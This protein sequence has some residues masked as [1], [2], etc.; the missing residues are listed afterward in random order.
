MR[1]W[2]DRF[3]DLSSESSEATLRF[4]PGARGLIL[5]VRAWLIFFNLPSFTNLRMNIH[6]DVDGD[7][8]DLLFSSHT[9]I[10]LSDVTSL[11]FAMKEI[12]F[13]FNPPWGVRLDTGF[14]YHLVLS[15]DDYDGTSESHI[16][17]VKAWPIPANITSAPT[18]EGLA[19]APYAVIF[20]GANK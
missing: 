2:G 10:S 16:A 19:R 3:D 6:E 17:A 9:S 20:I 18:L 14:Y 4:R 12:S 15:A 5:A 13:E 11:V 7:T 8:G 1:V